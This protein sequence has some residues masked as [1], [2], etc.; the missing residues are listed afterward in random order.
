MCSFGEEIKEW[1]SL[2]ERHLRLT[3][4]PKAKTI[5]DT[6]SQSLAKFYAVVPKSLS[7]INQALIPM[8]LTA[9]AG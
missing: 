2:L 5:L 8:P 3:Q 7:E 1:K 4:S 6:W 9:K